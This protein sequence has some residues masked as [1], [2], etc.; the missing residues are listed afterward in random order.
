M[1]KLEGSHFGFFKSLIGTKHP[2]NTFVNQCFFA[3]KLNTIEDMKVFCMIVDRVGKNTWRPVNIGEKFMDSGI[4]CSIDYF[5]LLK[6]KINNF[7]GNPCVS[8]SDAISIYT[9]L[10]NRFKVDGQKEV[11][12]KFIV[13]WQENTNNIR[14]LKTLMS[15]K[16]LYVLS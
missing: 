8:F 9:F 13:K 7:L 5:P 2:T 16:P 4:E 14:I 6:S 12:E 3:Q 1:I 10:F 11:I 15:M